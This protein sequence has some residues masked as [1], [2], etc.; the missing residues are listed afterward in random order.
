MAFRFQR[1][2]RLA[3]GVRL[4]LSKRGLGLSV[5]P[6]GASLSMGPGGVHGHAGVP[7][8]G[9]AYRRKLTAGG[10]PRRR[11]VAGAAATESGN[12]AALE[13]RLAEGETLAL[14]LDVGE[15]GQVGYFHTDGKPLSS[16]EARVLRRHAEDS[17]REQLRAHCERLNAD[18]DRLGLHSRTASCPLRA[19]QRRPRPPGAAARGDAAARIE[20][21]CDAR[22]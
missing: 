4:N 21:L 16:P 5:G 11:G 18:L 17:I 9:L 15:G 6:R 22:L 7:G 10:G 14:Q 8:T 12:A 2:I 13:A 19:A 20:G 3:P 1:R